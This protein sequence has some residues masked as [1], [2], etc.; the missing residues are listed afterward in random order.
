MTAAMKYGPTSFGRPN[1]AANAPTKP[2]PAPVVSITSLFGAVVF[3]IS[4]FLVLKIAPSE[5]KV[6]KRFFS[7]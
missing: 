4:P 2:S 1:A 3:I 7:G 5:P 6:T